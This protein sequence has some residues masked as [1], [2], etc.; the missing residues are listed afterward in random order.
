MMKKEG[1]GSENKAREKEE[2]ARLQEEWV[3]HRQKSRC[4]LFGFIRWHELIR[5]LLGCEGVHFPKCEEKKEHRPL[6]VGRK[7]FYRW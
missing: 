2:G 1:C 4:E 3:R 6:C 7:R 5:H